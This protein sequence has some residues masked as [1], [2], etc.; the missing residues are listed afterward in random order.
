MSARKLTPLA[1]LAAL[2]IVAAACAA[3]ASRYRTD[4][5]TF[6]AGEAVYQAYGVVF[7]NIGCTEPATTDEGATFEC[8]ADGDDG[9]SYGFTLTIVG[10]NTLEL[11]D[12]VLV[13]APPS[14]D[15]AASSEPESTEAGGA[16]T[17]TAPAPAPAATSV[18]PTSVAPTTGAPTTV[19]PTAAQT[20]T[21][22]ASPG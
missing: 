14:S 21:T 1:T 19:A 5:I 9:Q 18:A 11:T 20:T 13:E 10:K 22:T 3:P 2:A 15:V 12:I 8:R 16:P 17:V 6:I 4:A 7:E